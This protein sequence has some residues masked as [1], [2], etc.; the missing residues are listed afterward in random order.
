[1]R[2]APK[3]EALKSTLHR[4][5]PAAVIIAL[6]LPAASS[7]QTETPGRI[8][9]RTELVVVPVT[10]KDRQGNL[11]PDLRREEFRVFD[12]NVEQ[13][14][15]LFSADPFPLSAVV[16]I[17]NGLTTTE[18]NQV[19]KSL[20]S[21]AAGFGAPDEVALML[22]D[23][24]TD[25]ILDFTFDNDKLFTQLK[26][27]QIRSEFPG[28]GSPAMTGGPII[29]GRSDMP[30]VPQ[31]SSNSVPPSQVTT[32]LNDALYAAA[33]L[34]RSRGRDR[35]KIIFLISDG[36]NSH[37]N[38]MSY[39]NTIQ[40]LLGAD[41][42]VYAVAIGPPLIK[43]GTSYLVRYSTTTGGDYFY[44]SKNT[45]LDRLYSTLTEQARMQY[46][47]AYV[48]HIPASK[49]DFHTLEV[50]VKR[51]DLVLTARQGYYTTVPH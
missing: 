44:A 15:V 47:I 8:R 11:V 10:V 51:P 23:T 1:M 31:V 6:L 5:A 46:T 24:W 3:G 29:N 18:A 36:V 12:N 16:L 42:A 7:A 28:Q 40:M 38:T 37:H 21:I 22:Y 50:R 9:T 25:P 34:L 17:R 14:I 20:V 43:Q 45:E 2:A 41:I 33:E 49:K 30:N 48:P 4:I 32:N 19:Q 26:R 13:Q 39:E 35:R 27:L